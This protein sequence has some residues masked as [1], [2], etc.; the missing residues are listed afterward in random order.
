MCVMGLPLHTCIVEIFKSTEV[1]E[2]YSLSHKNVSMLKEE[3]E[4]KNRHL[5]IHRTM[6]AEKNP[7]NPK[8]AE[9]I[10]HPLSLLRIAYWKDKRQQLQTTREI[11]VEYE[12]KIK[13]FKIWRVAKRDCENTILGDTP[14]LEIYK[15]YQ[16][17]VQP[18]T[19]YGHLFPAF[20]HPLPPFGQLPDSSIELVLAL[21][22]TENFFIFLK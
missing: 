5:E 16:V 12:K 13:M 4:Y 1:N 8:D 7:K 21:V 3:K 17:N 19:L 10:V 6:K 9:P 22:I 18:Y 14:S 20:N 15:I 11:P 2:G